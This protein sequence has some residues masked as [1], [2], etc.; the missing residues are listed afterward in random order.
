M[1]DYFILQVPIS[2]QGNIFLTLLM[3]LELMMQKFF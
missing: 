1:V 2:I 3:R